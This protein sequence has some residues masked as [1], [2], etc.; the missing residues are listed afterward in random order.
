MRS[1]F[2]SGHQSGI[3][4]SRIFSRSAFVKYLAC[5]CLRCV[6]L[7]LCFFPAFLCVLNG[8]A[9][10]FVALALS[11][12]VGRWA[13]IAPA[14]AATASSAAVAAQRSAL[15][16]LLLPGTGFSSGASPACSSSVPPRLLVHNILMS[17]N[18][19]LL[20]IAFAF[21]FQTAT[22]ESVMAFI[23]L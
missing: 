14:A 8:F 11:E 21:W 16:W 17:Q 13:Q 6:S 4:L 20:G 12:S 2:I 18:I 10:F 15:L 22:I 1:K 7:V 19:F 23:L 3:V 9:F 5:A